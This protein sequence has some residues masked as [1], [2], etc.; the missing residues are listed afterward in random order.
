MESTFK[1]VFLN[2]LYDMKMNNSAN[3]FSC[4]ALMNKD[5]YLRINFGSNLYFLE[6]NQSNYKL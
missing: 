1:S 6:E 4:E 5:G 2:I 3:Q